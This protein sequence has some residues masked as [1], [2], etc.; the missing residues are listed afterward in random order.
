[1]TT[2]QK[3]N[4]IDQS[5]LS[6]EAK[7]TLEKM[8]KASDNFKNEAITKKVD[9]ALDQLIARLKK[10]KPEAIKKTP[11]ATKKKATPKKTPNSNKGGVMKLAKEIR[12]EG[13]SWSDAVKRAGEQMKKGEKKAESE[14]K[15]ELDKLKDL[16]E[17][18]EILRGFKNSDVSRDAK[19]KAKP[20]GK[21]KS[22][23]GWKNQYGASKGGRTYYENR[24][25]RS[26]RYSPKY[27]KDKPFLA[28][29]GHLAQGDIQQLDIANADLFA[30]G[31]EIKET[32]AQL[33]KRSEKDSIRIYNE[34]KKVL[35]SNF[36]DKEYQRFEKLVKDTQIPSDSVQKIQEYT[37]TTPRGQHKM[38]DIYHYWGKD[39]Y[40]KGGETR[41]KRSINTDRARLSKEPWE[42]AYL[43]KRKGSYYA[44]G[45]EVLE[46]F[47]FDNKSDADEFLQ[48]IEFAMP[49]SDD[50]VRL[51]DKAFQFLG[52]NEDRDF[53]IERAS[54]YDSYRSSYAKGG[55]LENSTYIPKE[56]VISVRLRNGKQYE[57][58]YSEMEFL[59]GVYISDS[60]ITKE[61]DINENQMSLFKKGGKLP[62][63]SIYI[64]RRD[65]DYV[66]YGDFDE[67][68]R[69]DG[70]NLVGGIWIDPKK[71]KTLI[72]KARKEGRLESGGHLAQGDIQQL[73]IAN[74][75]LFANGGEIKKDKYGNHLEP[76]FKKGDKVTYLGH[77][78][79]ITY[80]N[81]ESTGVYTY[82]VSYNSGT[83]STKVTNVSNKGEQIKRMFA[84]GGYL[85]DHGLMAGDTIIKTIGDSQLIENKYG[86]ILF[87]NLENGSRDNYSYML[88]GD[89]WNPNGM[90][91]VKEYFAKNEKALA[92]KIYNEL[93][94]ENYTV[95]LFDSKGNLLKKSDQ[96]FSENFEEGGEI[97]EDK[98]YFEHYDE[99][100]P[101]IIELIDY[102]HENLDELQNYEGLDKVKSMFEEK[103]WT[104]DYGLDAEPYNL[105]PLKY[106]QGGEI[107]AFTLS[108]VRGNDETIIDSKE[109]KINFKKGGYIAMYNGKTIS[110]EADSLYD[111]KKKAVTQLKVPKT[112]TGLLSVV[113]ND[114]MTNEDF[115]FMECGGY[116]NSVV[117]DSTSNFVNY[118][119]EKGGELY[120]Y[121]P[122]KD[123]KDLNAT[124]SGELKRISTKDILSGVYIKSN[125]TAKSKKS[126]RDR[127]IEYA[128]SVDSESAK[129]YFKYVRN[130]DLEYFQKYATDDLIM[131][132][133]CGV[134]SVYDFQGDYE[135]S[136]LAGI[137]D[138]REDYID[139]IINSTKK[140]CRKGEFELG[141]KYPDYDFEKLLGKPKEIKKIKGKENSRGETYEYKI[142]IWDNLV[143]G[144]FIGVYRKDG[145]YGDYTYGTKFEDVL[146]KNGYLGFVSSDPKKI[147]MVLSKISKVKNGYVKNVEVLNNGLG[148]VETSA[149]NK[150]KI[151]YNQGGQLNN[152]VDDSLSHFD[153]FYLMEGSGAGMFAKGGRL[154]SALNRD[155]KYFNKNES[156]ERAYSKGKNRKG[157]KSFSKGGILS[158]IERYVLEIE[159]ITGI[160]KDAVEKFIAENNLTDEQVLHI[161]IGLGRKQLKASEFRGAA[162][163]NSEKTKNVLKFA[164]SK[165]AVM[166]EAG[167]DTR[168][169]EIVNADVAYTPSKY[170]AIYEDY[171]NDGTV[172]I[173]DANP[174]QAD[175]KNK[176]EQ[177]ELRE[178]F[179]KLLDV[180][181]ELDDIMNNAVKTLDEKAPKGADIYARTK[182]PYS[183]IKKLVEKRMLDPEKGLTDMI[184]TTIAVD[185]QAQ[186]EDVR[187]QID[188]GL[189]G[190]VLDRDDYYKSP[191]AGY[192]AYHYI[193][194]YE[195]VPVEVQLKTKQ[196][197]KLHEISHEYYKK[198][199][200][201][202]TGLN[203][204]SILIEKSDRGDSKSKAKVKELFKSK[205]NLGKKIASKTFKKGGAIDDLR[206][207][208]R[209]IDIYEDVM[210]AKGGKVTFEQKSKAIAKNFE[211]NRV[212]PKYQKEYG[213]TYSKEEAMEVGNKI[214]GAQKAEYD[215]K[216]ENG[217]KTATRKRG[218][219]NS[220]FSRAKKIRKQGETWQAAVKRAKIELENEK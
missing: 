128:E 104:F 211:G 39:T 193:V 83:G 88:T 123:I 45:G 56:N 64:K 49:D 184:G 75:D 3:F 207:P 30:K 164:K 62:K 33:K 18:D 66:E 156:W 105:K 116:L 147:E 114:S 124:I 48:T 12:K 10:E 41:S 183:I 81:R 32:S 149:L 16:I 61:S 129:P 177:V 144:K 19:L 200:L 151:K 82:N 109:Q 2:K 8:K 7:S 94:L 194:Q 60:V 22:T 219:P 71:Q 46:I 178:T 162:M 29:G 155:R 131:A 201:N 107:D 173:D 166:L 80:V 89:F 142:W 163:G 125:T 190:K 11:I 51:N 97:Y 118:Y 21:R 160:R 91:K 203:Q 42:Q 98:D 137:F 63:G 68:E 199:T 27:P 14:V 37:T 55:T 169:I 120:D 170:K 188:N 175:K 191:K 158:P 20:K 140:I 87:V 113:S 192:R 121:V 38:I 181:A 168:K 218:N 31:G 130:S 115:R 122:Q 150:N 93:R 24:E 54:S 78:G 50:L 52:S 6:K 216:L 92:D 4:S 159:G 28:S 206:K 217:G 126:L 90:E 167:G 101:E 165:K 185:N 13:E 132:F 136:E 134:R 139:E 9:A 74:A 108:T 86:D 179:D 70:K 106:A 111:A 59:N 154:K 96:R 161:V 25:N 77:K 135:I 176:V 204:V 208:M 187:D 57:N 174:L 47:E 146:I 85:S 153:N 58:D 69:V 26:D 1:M 5:K 100:P 198:G 197:K 138:L 103:G 23:A 67:P 15:N 202:P 212:E 102:Y 189:L 36:G 127:I 210:L 72:E 157:Y 34:W 215:S 182:T 214:A 95:R 152:I 180:K 40:A 44:K 110:I 79:E 76:Q 205:T 17:N 148:G 112:K 53:L 73:D 145:T 171:D 143:A 172:N 141:L 213:K 186:L 220:V 133:Y 195:G 43:P 65:I 99:I 209:N 84:E 117:S 196:Q 35:D 119:L